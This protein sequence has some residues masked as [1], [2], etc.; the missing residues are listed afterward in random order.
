MDRPTNDANEATDTSTAEIRASDGIDPDAEPIAVTRIGGVTTALVSPG[1]VNPINGQAAIISLAGRTTAEMLVD[2]LRQKDI[3]AVVHSGTG[4]FGFTGQLGISSYRPIGGG[5]S[6]FV[7][8]EYIVD[9]DMESSIII[10][11][12]WKELKLI[13]IEGN[14][15]A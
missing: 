15:D 14:D 7:P 9:A 6:L 3:P 12:E 11:E 2:A 8:K 10:G 4:H 1:K 5:Y 13:D